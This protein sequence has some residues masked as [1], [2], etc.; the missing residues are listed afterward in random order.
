M[1]T[2]FKKIDESIPF[3]KLTEN[4]IR[5]Q[6]FQLPFEILSCLGMEVAQIIMERYY[7]TEAN[8]EVL[9]LIGWPNGT[10]ILI[11]QPEGEPI[12]VDMLLIEYLE[13][14][15]SYDGAYEGRYS[16]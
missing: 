11:A 4:E 2:T 15:F 7:D 3:K 9:L 1:N 8:G 16:C 6:W 14:H 13:F 10:Q 5:T 12:D